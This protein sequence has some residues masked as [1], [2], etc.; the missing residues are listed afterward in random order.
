MKKMKYMK[1]HLRTN[2]ATN[3]AACGDGS[4]ASGTD[5]GVMAIGTLCWPGTGADTVLTAAH[6]CGS[7]SGDT[8]DYYNVS[9]LTDCDTGAV[10]GASYNGTACAT[11]TGVS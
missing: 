10:F 5:R 1:P 9:D 3:Q 8:Q 6:P 7:G 2:S 11:G 4:S